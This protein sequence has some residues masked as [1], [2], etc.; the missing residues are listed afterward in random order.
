[1]YFNWDWKV[2]YING[3]LIAA[4]FKMIMYFLT[5]LLGQINSL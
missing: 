2:N 5:L 4:Q 3:H 1:M